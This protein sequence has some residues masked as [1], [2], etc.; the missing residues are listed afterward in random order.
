M[1]EINSYYLLNPHTGN[2]KKQQNKKEITLKETLDCYCS[3]FS[4]QDVNFSPSRKW[5]LIID[6]LMINCLLT[7]PLGGS[8]S[9]IKR[10]RRGNL[11]LFT[12]NSKVIVEEFPEIFLRCI[13]GPPFL[14]GTLIDP[15]YLSNF[16]TIHL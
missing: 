2:N 3:F 15:I 13:R 4:Y 14:F 11:P 1:R 16:I 6:Q 12:C 7:N 5:S 10:K 9:S 8:T